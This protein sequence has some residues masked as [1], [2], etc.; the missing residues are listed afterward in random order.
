MKKFMNKNPDIL[1][2]G[3]TFAVV[4]IILFFSAPSFIE[5]IEGKK[6]AK[7]VSSAFHRQ[8]N[9]KGHPRAKIIP[10]SKGGTVAG[11]KT[12]QFGA[13]PHHID[14]PE[15]QVV[16][17]FFHAY[18]NNHMYVKRRFQLGGYTIKEKY[19]STSAYETDNGPLVLV[20]HFIV[21]QR[22]LNPDFKRMVLVENSLWYDL[23]VGD[24]FPLEVEADDNRKAIQKKEEQ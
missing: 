6:E 9:E 12:S 5:A 21:V 7:F 15:F 23:N 18:K 4:A 20:W 8:S 22:T 10:A 14:D 13:R 3:A 17:I 11:K 2:M 16:H 19:M 24:S 1:L